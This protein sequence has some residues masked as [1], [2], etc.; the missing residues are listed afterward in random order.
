[1]TVPILSRLRG[2]IACRVKPA[3]IIRILA[4]LETIDRKADTIMATVADVQAALAANESKETTIIGLLQAE[5][6]TLKETQAQLAAAIAGGSD[7]TALQGVVD[8]LAADSAAM[9]AAIA[10]V[11]PTP[12]DTGSSITGAA[13]VG[14]AATIGGADTTGGATG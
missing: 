4:Q 9:D 14:G 8:K 2:S 6:A 10:S 11:A 3:V 7:A 12:V 13:S 5:A 1:M